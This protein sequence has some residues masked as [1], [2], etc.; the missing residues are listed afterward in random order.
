MSMSTASYQSKKPT[1]IKKLLLDIWHTRFLQLLIL[2]GLIY[3][4]IFKY[5]PIYGV[6]IAFKDYK[7]ALGITGSPWVGLKHFETFFTG[8]YAWRLIRNTLLLNFYNLIFSF[9]LPIIFAL[10]LNEVKPVLFKKFVQTVSYLPHFISLTA[11]IGMLSMFVSPSIGIVNKAIQAFGFEP[12]YFMSEPAW[13]RP[14]YVLSG[15]WT[16]LGWGAIIY[17]AALAG[18]DQGL[19]EAA[20]IDGANRFQLMWHVSLPSIKGTIVI[21]F[22]MRVGAMMSVGSEKVL[23]MYNELTY[24]TA[25]V[26]ST[27]VYRRGLQNNEY[28]FSTAV[29]VFNSVVNIILLICANTISRKLTESSLW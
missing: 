4:I 10:L 28:S 16:G 8:P 9:P 2:P 18:V 1:G 25:D 27:F 3:F 21:M 24:E 11:I 19:Y 5:I 17:I 20:A 29:D 7:L 26:I 14:L 13:F 12:I 15:I 22:I 6:Q 23:L